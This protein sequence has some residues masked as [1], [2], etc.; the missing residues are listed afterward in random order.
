M[1]VTKRDASGTFDADLT[2]KLSKQAAVASA[3]LQLNHNGITFVSARA[4]PEWTELDVQ[5]RLPQKGSSKASSVTCRS[6]VVQCT[7]RP[8]ATGYEISLLFLDLPKRAHPQLDL[9]TP[10]PTAASIWISR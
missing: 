5:I 4:F 6:V 3:P 10:Q 9:R 7:K 8:L 1:A 2:G